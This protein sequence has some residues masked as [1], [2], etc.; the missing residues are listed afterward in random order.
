MSGRIG[1]P[2]MIQHL[3]QKARETDLDVVMWSDGPLEELISAI[4]LAMRSP[5]EIMLL[6]GRRGKSLD[7]PYDRDALLVWQDMIDEALK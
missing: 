4:L 7:I 1:P 3:M 6:Y 5:T 2:A